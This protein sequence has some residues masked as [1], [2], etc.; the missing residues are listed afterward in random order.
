VWPVANLDARARAEPRLNAW[1]GSVL[2]DPARIRVAVET[3]NPASQREVNIAD[4]GLSPLSL[5]LASEDGSEGRASELEERIVHSV[6]ATIT[7]PTAETSIRL[8]D[9]PATG[10]PAGTVGLAALRALLGWLRTLIT[11]HRAIDARDFS[12]PQDLKA[13]GV[14]VAELTA[15]SNAVVVAIRKARTTLGNLVA[16]ATPPKEPALRKA[17]MAI[18]DLGI[19]DALPNVAPGGVDAAPELFD[20]VEAVSKTIGAALARV[21]AED[22]DFAARV[23]SSTPPDADARA[24]HFV[25][26]VRM[27][28]GNHFPILPRFSSANAPE[29]AASLGQRNALCG[30]DQFAPHA[31]LARLSL[32]RPSVD[33]LARVLS[34]AE[35]AGASAG[36]LAL[37]QLPFTPGERWLALPIA[38]ADLQG[39]VAIVAAWDGATDPSKPLAGLFCDAWSEIIPSA[40]ETTGVS[41]HYDA[42][43]ARAPQTILIAVSPDPAAKTWSFDA[44]LDT[45]LEAHDLGRIRAVGPKEL[46]HL[47][48][49][50]P[51]I[52]LPQSF[53]KD[54]PSVRL[55]SIVTKNLAASG[56]RTRVLGK[57]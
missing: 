1:I 49:M 38:S 26:R 15:R 57:S 7:V 43:G 45:V 30:G 24:E 22:A 29:L 16:A 23:A 54:I 46:T 52:Y 12:L 31:W 25:L 27:L 33:K 8:L 37:L 21:D 14:D 34:A 56:I 50:L 6:A 35:V 47:G 4:L 40:V 44:L 9:A 2:G 3:T 17:L 20:Q 32:V 19:R 13:S 41:F 48:V 28:L 42:P 39:E 5:V 53:S 36:D 51:C 18:A 55:D 11:E 10:A